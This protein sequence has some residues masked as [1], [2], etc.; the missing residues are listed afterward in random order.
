MNREKEYTDI[1]PPQALD[2]ER[3]V[4]GALM[5]DQDV[6]SSVSGIID[7]PSFYNPQ[8]QIVF[9]AIKALKKQSRGVDLVSV[10]QFLRDKN[11]L[12]SIGGALYVTQLIDVSGTF[13]AEQHARIIAEM[14]YKRELIRKAHEI[15]KMVYSGEDTD[16][17]ANE[18]KQAGEQ[19]EN[20]FTIADTG[21]RI[22]EV[23]RTTLKDIERDCVLA[24]ER[25]TPGITT[26]FESLN[27]NTGGWRNGNLCILAARPGVGK[28]SFALHFAL[29]AANTGYWVNI[30]SLEMNKEDLARILLASESGVYRSDIRD[31]YLNDSDWDPINKAISKLENLPII[32]RDAAGMT[33][34]QIQAAIHKNRKNKRCDFAIVDYLQLV[35]S[36]QSKAIREL[37]VSEISRTLKTT[38]L[39]E[40]LPILALSQ[41]NRAADGETPKLSNLRESGAIE[42]D[43]DLVLF[44]HR[45][46]TK[47]SVIRLTVA[48]HRRGRLGEIDIQAND[49]MTRFI[50]YNPA[51]S[52]DPDYQPDHRIESQYENEPF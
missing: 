9:E 3:A 45:P 32:F 11:Q 8:H 1:L 5:L 19:L 40:N 26:G 2:A 49:E 14:F 18:W 28:T 7:T 24:K 4:L 51:P 33:V 43:A 17:L 46:D 10:T 20:V 35:R 29:A 23:L 38:A 44:L 41:L 21:T 12:E 31:G 52:T 16:T 34:N 30:F 42:Q 39:A 15:I 47:Q 36:Q 37:E 13:H 27:E 22:K 48:K 6:Y 50:E 25:R